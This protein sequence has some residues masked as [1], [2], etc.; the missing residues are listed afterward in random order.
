MT[1]QNF[2]RVTTQLEPGQKLKVDV[3]Q[4]KE[5]VSS[6]DC[7]AFLHSQQSILVGVQG[8]SLVYEEKREKLPKNRGHISFDE[9]EAL[10]QDAG[11][12]RRVPRIEAVTGGVFGFRLGRFESPWVGYFC[13]LS[14]RDE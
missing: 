10:W 4:I 1:D 7:L 9:K 8:A 6:E 12:Y 14:F 13:L 2:S 5:T 11:G 3:F